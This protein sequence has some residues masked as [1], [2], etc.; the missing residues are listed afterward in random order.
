MSTNQR[1][2]LHMITD[3]MKQAEELRVIVAKAL[4]GG[5]DAIQLRYK[6]APALDIYLLG[7]ILKPAIDRSGANLLINDRVDVALALNANGVHLAGKS[8]P[9]DAA[10][11]ATGPNML[12]G[13]SVH[14]VDEAKRAEELGAGY[15][16]YGHIFTTNSKPGLPPRGVEGLQE[17]V[18]AVSI[19]VLAIGGITAENIDQVLATGCAGIAVIGAISLDRDPEAA[20]RLLREK[21]DRSPHKPRFCLPRG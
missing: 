4:H 7:E 15:I 11:K 17:V 1:F 12:L 10:R 8:L 2:Q 5:V 3:G 19:P 6:S 13:C 20:A 9:V 14:S 21:M 16:T 18:D